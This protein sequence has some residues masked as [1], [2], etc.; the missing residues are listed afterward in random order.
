MNMKVILLKEIPK[1]GKAGEVKNVA[2]GYARNFL[3]P[4]GFVTPA[5]ESRLRAFAAHLAETERREERERAEY[6][7]L[8][9][10]IQSRQFR[11]TVKTGERGKAFGS[12][13]ASDIAH[14]LL[15]HDITV[16]KKWIELE[17][18]VK[19]S[20]QHRIPVRL[21]HQI[22]AELTMIVEPSK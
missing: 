5:T 22:T 4:Q 8:A 9:E 11:F 17:S 21:P 6:A 20:G 7:A 3:I 10:K 14:E 2:D 19:S 12:I 18:P 1:L 15:K 16:E 13:T